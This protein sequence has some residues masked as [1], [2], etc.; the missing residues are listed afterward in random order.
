MT[1]NK[2]PNKLKLILDGW[3]NFTFPN[4]QVEELAKV[5]ADICSECPHA[6][7]EYPFKKMIPEEGRIEKIKGLGCDKCGCPLSS[8]LRAVMEKCPL[9]KW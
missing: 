5:R 4:S 9:N 8:K 7:P 6:N 2:K 3:K 1:T